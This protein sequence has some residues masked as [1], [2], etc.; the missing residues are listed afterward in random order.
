MKLLKDWGFTDTG[1]RLGSRGEYFVLLQGALL[2]GFVF[3]PVWHP[4]WLMP[5]PGYG[6]AALKVIAALLGLAAA[7][8]ILKGLLDL[9]K[10]LTP[11][12]YPKEDG[13]LVQTGIYKMVRHPLYT[14]L[15]LAA[16]S[17]TIFLVSL[18]H[19][20]GTFVLF[21]FLDAK[22]TREEAWL[23]QKYPDYT[24]YK[25]RVKKLVPKLY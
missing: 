23:C 6:S 12:P 19:L 14:G 18:S 16:L 9:G 8:F 1:W 24:D 4:A 17:W 21:A 22:A 20:L 10:N 7:I 3:L 11:L 25:K 15:I 2:I 5:L 13:Y